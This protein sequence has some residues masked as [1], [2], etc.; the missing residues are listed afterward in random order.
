VSRGERTGILIFAAVAG[1]FVAIL[2]LG[3][4]NWLGQQ[5]WFSNGAN[6]IQWTSGPGT[7]FGVS[8]GVMIYLNRTCAASPFCFRHGEHPVAGT[9]KKVCTHHHTLTYHE[10][11]HD[12]NGAAHAASGRLNRGE[13][14]NRG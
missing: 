4:E 7:F 1:A 14:H 12:K 5:G 13:S 9:L 2:V 3:V 11:V 10:A 8:A 6:V